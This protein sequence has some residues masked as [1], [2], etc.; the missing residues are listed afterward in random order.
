[1]VIIGAGGHGRQLRDIIGA[2]DRSSARARHVLG[3]LD[4]GTVD[5]ALL[6]RCGDR[7]L[8]PTSLIDELDVDVAIGIAHPATRRRFGDAASAAGRQLVSAVHPTAVVGSLFESG[9]GL[10]LSA[11][12]I[13]DTNVRFGRLCHLNLHTSV[14]HDSHFGDH[15]TLLPGARVSG[16]VTIG[17]DVVVATNAVV[18]PGVT[19]GERTIVGAGAVVRKDLQA[20]LTYVGIRRAPDGKA[21]ARPTPAD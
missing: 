9:P 6:R 2:E 11:G 12:S 21:T 5:E 17:D 13:V 19:I 1:L 8:G 10:M 14:G 16:N 20:D 18:F 15:V 4:D 3:F 7:W